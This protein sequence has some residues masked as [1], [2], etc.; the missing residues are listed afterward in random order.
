MDTATVN[1]LTFS[2]QSETQDLLE[3]NPLKDKNYTQNQFHE[4][5]NVNKKVSNINNRVRK[6]TFHRIGR[7]TA[8]TQR[9]AQIVFKRLGKLEVNNNLV[10]QL[11]ITDITNTNGTQ[12][13]RKDT[14]TVSTQVVMNL[15]DLFITFILFYNN[16]LILQVGPDE[17][18]ASNTVFESF[19]LNSLDFLEPT[20]PSMLPSNKKKEEVEVP[21]IIQVKKPQFSNQFTSDF[22]LFYAGRKKATGEQTQPRNQ[23]QR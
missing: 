3:L 16:Y 18:M 20:N 2:V 7:L 15:I 4:V 5:T 19:P 21:L 22:F 10:K 23:Q 13:L 1:R 6:V 9:R 12:T 17:F 8:K 11:L 14:C